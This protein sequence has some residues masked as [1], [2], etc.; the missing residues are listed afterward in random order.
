[1]VA[2]S[3]YPWVIIRPHLEKISV[4]L[5]IHIRSV[6]TNGMKLLLTERPSIKIYL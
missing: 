1:M 2:L 6:I 5:C 3:N 4:I